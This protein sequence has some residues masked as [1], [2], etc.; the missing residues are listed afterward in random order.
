MISHKIPWQN[1][2][3][4]PRASDSEN[5]CSDRSCETDT[6]AVSKSAE[7]KRPTQSCPGHTAMLGGEA[8]P[9]SLVEV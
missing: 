3:S 2:D 1:Q 7:S 4:D 9:M 6:R 8:L 5:L